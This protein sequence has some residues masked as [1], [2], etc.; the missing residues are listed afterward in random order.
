MSPPDAKNLP[1]LSYAVAFLER[2]LRRALAEALSPF[3]LTLAHY[4][5]LSLLGLRDAL[6]NAQLARRAYV[7]PQAMSEIVR[8][9]ESRGLVVRAPS[10][11]H[12]RIHPARLTALGRT[13]LDKCDSAVDRVE[14]GLVGGTAPDPAL[15][16]TLMQYARA[17]EDGAKTTAKP[18]GT[19]AA[20]A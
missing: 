15:V 9:L 12:A 17:L 3:D 2:S 19:D 10:P 4:T 13:V 1:R 14:N 11:D 16:Q 6:S 20:G 8:Y 7:T 5:V 18:T